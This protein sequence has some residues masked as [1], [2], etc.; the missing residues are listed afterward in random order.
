M[1]ECSSRNGFRTLPTE[2]MLANEFYIQ[3]RHAARFGWQPGL[4]LATISFAFVFSSIPVL[5]DSLF[6]TNPTDLVQ[7]YRTSDATEPVYKAVSSAVALVP[8]GVKQTLVD[9]GVRWK[10]VPTLV[11]YD[12]ALASKQA[13]G[14]DGRDYRYVA[15]TYSYKHNEVLIAEQALRTNDNVAALKGHRLQ[16]TLHE[17]GHAY[18]WKLKQYSKRVLFRA[19]YDNDVSQ[20]TDAL[21]QKL[22][23]YMQPDDGGPSETFAELFADGIMQMNNIQAERPFIIQYFPRSFEVARE[24]LK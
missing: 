10:I 20:M 11:E 5:A 6:D 24:L 9:A 1:L 19:A 18:D 14:W 23:Y 3:K 12:P 22:H 13:R 21:K 8:T 15:G 4:L 16:T 2:K 17:T 7:I